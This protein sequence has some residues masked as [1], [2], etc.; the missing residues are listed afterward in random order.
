MLKHEKPVLPKTP[1]DPPVQFWTLKKGADRQK[2]YW[3]NIATNTPQAY[4]PV[5]G[6]GGI[7]ADGMGLGKTLTTIT[8]VLATKGGYIAHGYRGTTLIG[9]L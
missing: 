3:L 5:L 8:L 2:D 1:E 6:R 4:P 9:G 7:I